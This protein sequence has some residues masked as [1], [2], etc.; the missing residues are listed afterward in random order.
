MIH[1][2]CMNNTL[3]SLKLARNGLGKDVAALLKYLVK[4]LYFNRVALRLVSRGAL[5]LKKNHNIKI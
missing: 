5:H 1:A 2:L 3:T 4:L